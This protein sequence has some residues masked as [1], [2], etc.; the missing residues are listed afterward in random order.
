VTGDL[1]AAAAGPAASEAV[2]LGD[3]R[4]G[5]GTATGSVALRFLEF[6]SA[7]CAREAEDRVD[8][9]N[10]VSLA[11]LTDWRVTRATLWPPERGCH[12]AEDSDGG[13]WPRRWREHRGRDSVLAEAASRISSKTLDLGAATRSLT[14]IQFLNMQKERLG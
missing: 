13:G 10:S 5:T 2:F 8:L 7:S 4:D 6:F 12:G 14:R 3:F 1:M 9:R 11:V